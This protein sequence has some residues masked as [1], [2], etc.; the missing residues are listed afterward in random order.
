MY[1]I[2]TH[3][4]IFLKEFDGDRKEVLERAETVGVKRFFLPNI[5]L[6]SAENLHKLCNSFPDKCFP[7]MGLHPT[8]VSENYK[9]DLDKIRTYFEQ[10]KYIAVGEIGIDLYWDK[11]FRSE[12]IEAFEIQLEWS[13][14][15]NL[16]VAIHTREAFPEVFN[17]LSKIGADRL[18]GIFH[19]FGGTRDELETALGF[20]NFLLGI[21]GSL[22]FKNSQLKDYLALAPIDRIVLETD[23]PYL[24]PVPHRGKRNEPSYIIF[25]AM[26]LAEIYGVPLET[27]AETTSAN[28][29][30]FFSNQ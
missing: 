6:E 19:S 13:I 20:S 27:V 21:N 17:S 12:Q 23:A 9:T 28:A 24:S 18:R 11:T 1:L 14:E 26:K 15:M 2:D 16:P 3:T 10:K 8:S 22:T 4:H 5:D 7:M 30:K 29:E 25:T